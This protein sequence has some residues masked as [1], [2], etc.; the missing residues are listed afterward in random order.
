MAT[1][2]RS[3]KRR[4]AHVLR[5]AEQ[6]VAD[7]FAQ[8]RQ[9]WARGE[10]EMV[11]RRVRQARRAAMRVQLRIP[12]YWRRYCR[13]CDAYLVQGENSTVRVKGGVRI[14]RCAECGYVRRKVLGDGA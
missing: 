11:K 8:A 13:R 12:D 4:P 3:Y 5:K 6:A 7:L 2:K 1:E 14:L 9:E 10:R